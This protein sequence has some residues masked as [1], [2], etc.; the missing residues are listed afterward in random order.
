MSGD[1]V[2]KPQAISFPSFK[3]NNINPATN[4]SRILV[5]DDEKFNCDIILGFLMLLGLKNR[6]QRTAFAYNGEQAV[7]QVQQA[8]DQGDP[9]RFK[10]ILM[11][12]NMPFMDG[13]QATKNI[14]RLTQGLPQEDQPKIFAVTGHVEDEYYTK[15]ISAG[16]DQVY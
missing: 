15:A 9:T 16:M 2:N 6:H 1:G 11:D 4:T 7:A 13:Y 3:G 12:C 14:R 5:V 10:L 8:I